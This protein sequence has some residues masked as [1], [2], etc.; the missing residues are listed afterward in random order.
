DAIRSTPAKTPK[1]AQDD[2]RQPQQLLTELNLRELVVSSRWLLIPIG[3]VLLVGLVTAF[4][5]LLALRRSRVLPAKLKL[6]LGQLRR[7]RGSRGSSA[8]VSWGCWRQPRRCWW[9]SPQPRSP[10]S[11]RG[12]SDRPCERSTTCC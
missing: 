4:E 3:A 6:E 5:R 7:R 12:G 10:T 1:M 11:S 2:Y 9:R 8:D